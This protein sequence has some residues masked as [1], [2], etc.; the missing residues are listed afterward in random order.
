MFVKISSYL[1]AGA[2][3]IETATYQASVIGFIKHLGITHDEAVELLKS[4]VKL[5]REAVDNFWQVPSNR[6]GK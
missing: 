6:S 3:F 5:A 4:A 1:E 2:D